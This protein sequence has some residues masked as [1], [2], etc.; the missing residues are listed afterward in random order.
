MHAELHMNLMVRS[1]HDAGVY[2]V[3]VGIVEA[4]TI[5]AAKPTG[6]GPWL[7]LENQHLVT[8]AE[9]KKLVIYPM[10]LA[11]F[12]GIVHEIKPGFLTSNCGLK[13]PHISPMLIALGHFSGNAGIIVANYPHR[14]IHITVVENFDSRLAKVRGDLTSSPFV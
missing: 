11:Q 6:T 7:C 5:P 8:F 1:A 3:D 2:C 12:L 9:V 10:L 14:G 4:G 13:L